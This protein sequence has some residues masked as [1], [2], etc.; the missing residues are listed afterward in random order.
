MPLFWKIRLISK[1]FHYA[2]LQKYLKFKKLKDYCYRCGREARAFSVN[3]EWYLAITKNEKGGHFCYDCFSRMA[4]QKGLYST[5]RLM[6]RVFHDDRVVSAIIWDQTPEALT[7][8]RRLLKG[9]QWKVL[10]ISNVN[11]KDHIG[12]SKHELTAILEIRKKGS[13]D[14]RYDMTHEEGF[15]AFFEEE[16]QEESFL[17]CSPLSILVYDKRTEALM[18]VKNGLHYGYFKEHEYDRRESFE[19]ILKELPMQANVEE[20][21]ESINKGKIPSDR[22]SSLPFKVVPKKKTT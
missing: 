12:D 15:K 11:P 7:S 8:V 17:R 4:E 18:V 14:K 22:V 6:H 19:N 3:T 1:A 21:K 10:V 2:V 20:V 9:S 16:I 5:Y 13:L